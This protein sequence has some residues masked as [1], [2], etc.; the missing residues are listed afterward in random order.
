[1]DLPNLKYFQLFR[2][3]ISFQT[4]LYRGQSAFRRYNII[5]AGLHRNYMALATTGHDGG[6]ADVAPS[7]Q[8]I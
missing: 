2:H 3:L 4:L 5:T 7:P 1:M 6:T 8:R